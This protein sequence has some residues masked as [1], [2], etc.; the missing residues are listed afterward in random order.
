V[1]RGGAE[2]HEA[3]A[4]RYGGLAR[5]APADAW[6]QRWQHEHRRSAQGRLSGLSVFHS[7]I[8]LYGVFVWAHRPLNSP[9][10]RF[11]ARAEVEAKGRGDRG[12]VLALEAEVSR[13]RFMG[14][15]ARAPFLRT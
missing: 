6:P 13:L 1:E 8:S 3:G 7:K 10:R 12:D 4:C 9:K 5:R 2:R 11:P 15:T 14:S